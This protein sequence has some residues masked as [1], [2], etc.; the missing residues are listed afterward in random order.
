MKKVYTWRP[1]ELCLI[2]QNSEEVHNMQS[3]DKKNIGATIRI[4]QEI[5]CLPYAGFLCLFSP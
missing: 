1:S 5:Q 3:S 2:D 4:N